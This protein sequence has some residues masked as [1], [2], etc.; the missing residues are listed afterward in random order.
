[1]RGAPRSAGDGGGARRLR[2]PFAAWGGYVEPTSDP[3]TRYYT[4][5]NI[6]NDYLVDRELAR[7]S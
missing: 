7:R 3:R 4:K 2:D 6:H 5:A 1:M